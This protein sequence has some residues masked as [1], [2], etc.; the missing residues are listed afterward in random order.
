MEREA[1]DDRTAPNTGAHDAAEEREAPVERQL[2]SLPSFA[3]GCTGDAP[4]GC[5]PT[6]DYRHVAE[7]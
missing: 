7:G 5:L 4:D 6:G 1:T 2:K 3:T